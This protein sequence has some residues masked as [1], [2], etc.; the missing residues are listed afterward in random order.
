MPPSGGHLHDTVGEQERQKANDKL[1]V[2]E[3]RHLSFRRW[4]GPGPFNDSDVEWAVASRAPVSLMQQEVDEGVNVGKLFD[5]LFPCTGDKQPDNIFDG[6]NDGPNAYGFEE[7][8]MVQG[9]CVIMEEL[10]TIPESMHAHTETT[11]VDCEVEHLNLEPVG[12]GDLGLEAAGVVPI[13]EDISNEANVL[14]EACQPLYLGARSTMLTSTLLL[15]NIWTIHCR[16][17]SL[18]LRPRQG[19]C[20]VRA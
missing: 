2:W 7:L 12:Q 17:P 3:V 16:N 15:M 18:G 5:D 8:D 1:W 19:G 20:K 10:S 11:E 9:A 6:L 4:K 13:V 14:Q